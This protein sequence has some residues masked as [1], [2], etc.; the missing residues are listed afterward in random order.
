MEGVC[1]INL[2]CPRNEAD[3][4]VL[5]GRLASAGYAVSPD[6]AEAEVILVNTCAFV[7]DAVNESIEAVLLAAG[8]KTSGALR[9]LVVCGCLPQRYG[10]E[11]AGSLPEADAFVGVGCAHR[12]VEAVQSE[13]RVLLFGPPE[14]T[15]L[16]TAKDPRLWPG[17]STAY[18]KI[19]EGCPGRCTYC[20][21]P[22]LRG[23]LRSR[24][25]ED[26]EAETR[27]L[28]EMGAREIV[29]VAQETTAY[30]MDLPGA[31][32][33]ADLLPRVCEAA[34]DAWVRFLYGHPLRIPDRLLS[35]VNSL[36]Q[37]CPYFDVP[38]QHASDRI[39]KAMGRRYG[40]QD[41]V[42]LFS[43]IRDRVPDAVL[44][45][46]LMTGFPGETEEDFA[47]LADLVETVRFDHLGVF[48]YSDAEDLPSHRLE[49]PVPPKAAHARRKAL[50]EMQ[51]AISL[52]KLA[53]LVGKG[54]GVMILE[55]TGNPEAPFQ[56]RTMGQAP[57]IDGITRV[58]GRGA[59][60]GD[61]VRARVV[62]A[63]P[64]DLLA[65][66]E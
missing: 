3:G 9:R 25:P 12:I 65:E 61:L 36:P 15:P 45:T 57:G 4:E 63:G 46:T 52:D 8:Y 66:I 19:A 24:P 33:L 32:D 40:K 30:G 48:A 23:P 55:N 18:L 6:P 34:P 22:R 41:L 56:G 64:Y 50:L 27:A 20:A 35:A 10:K 60:P 11:L 31:G 37:V 28:Y 38:V 16:A 26:V 29:L 1:L 42:D 49:N 7:E 43:R 14:Q 2:G 39:L 59:K 54:I 58:R 17:G 5:L 47:K 44:R 51:A 62:A 21:I 13:K 53:V